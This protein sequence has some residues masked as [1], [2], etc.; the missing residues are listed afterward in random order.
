MIKDVCHWWTYPNQLS[1]SNFSIDDNGQDNDYGGG[2][3]DDFGGGDD[4]G[5]DF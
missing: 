2:G 1:Q 3:G 5:G 4:G